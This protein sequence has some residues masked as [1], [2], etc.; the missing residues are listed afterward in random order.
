MDGTRRETDASEVI[1]LTLDQREAWIEARRRFWRVI[2]PF[3]AAALLIGATLGAITVV[4]VISRNDA[5]RLADGLLV[6]LEQRIATEARGWLGPAGRVAMLLQE[7]QKSGVFREDVML[8]EPIGAALLNSVPQIASVYVGSM[9]GDFIMLRRNAEGGIDSRVIMTRPERSVINTM[10]GPDG[11]VL[12]STLDPADGFDPRARPWFQGALEADGLYWT[13]IYVF[14]SDRV[15]GLTVSLAFRDR[16]GTVRGVFGVDVRLDTLSAL[17]AQLDIGE[18]GRAMIIDGAGRLVAYPELERAVRQADDTLLPVRVDELGDPVL[19]RAFDAFRI[20]GPGRRRIEVD[21]A[22]HLTIAAP[23]PGVTGRDWSVLIVV[24]EDSYVGFVSRNTRIALAAAAVIALLALLLAWLLVRQGL[25]ADRTAQ[26]LRERGRAMAA[27]SDAFAALSTVSA[28]FDPAAEG[29]PR[30]VLEIVART[31]GARRASLWRLGAASR[32][33]RCVD[34]VD[35]EAA[36]HAAGT[37]LPREE[38]PEAV[39]ALLAGPLDVADTAQES[40]LAALH[41]GY[42]TAVGTR[43]LLSVPIRR[44]EETVGLLWIEDRATEAEGAVAFA[45]AAAAML[46]L[47]FAGQVART[48]P[49]EEPV[50]LAAAGGAAAPAAPQRRMPGDGFLGADRDRMFMQRLTARGIG[51]RGFAAEIFRGITVLVLRFTDPLALA[52]RAPDE[53]GSPLAD[54]AIRVLQEIASAHGIDYV[55]I[56]GESVVVADGFVTAGAERAAAVA[57]AA[58]DLQQQIAALFHSAEQRLS[59]RIGIDTGAVIGS[60]VGEDTRTY[61]IWGE[62]VRTAAAMAESGPEATIQITETT[63][64]LLG[65]GFLMQPRGRFW[66]DGGGELATFLLTARA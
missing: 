1:D 53:D 64:A 9:R 52:E 21:G 36:L 24:P 56:L 2:V 28:P 62:A 27:Q 12:R 55:R 40:R 59:F 11:S 38:M 57:S 50:R 29:G 8:A 23:L 32:S 22:A 18:G 16:R 4:H 44:G 30:Q 17:L 20:E 3:L 15:P 25:R 7:T 6:A 34:A 54:H 66:L 60:V 63:R 41:R 51:E 43:A 13:D 61:N 37:H 65:E 19:T 47:R 14:F 49:A 42:F 58:L 35:T 31:L 45:R 46:A 39:A 33:L 26:R 48:R 5:L 10:R